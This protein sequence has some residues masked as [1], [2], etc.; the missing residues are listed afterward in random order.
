MP[1]FTPLPQTIT[2]LITKLQK[3]QNYKI[4]KLQTCVESSVFVQAAGESR[5][6]STS[7][8]SRQQRLDAKITVCL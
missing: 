6:D 7:T 1:V 2:K 8:L 3:L 4:T 5:P